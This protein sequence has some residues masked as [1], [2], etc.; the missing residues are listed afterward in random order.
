[1]KILF[2]DTPC[3]RKNKEGFDLLVKKNTIEATITTD[4]NYFHQEYDLVII[5]SQAIPPYMFPNTKRIMYGPH[6]FV[7]ANGIWAGPQQTFPGHCFYNILSDWVYELQKEFNGLSLPAKM[8]PFPV[9]TDR[10]CPSLA[11]YKYDCFIYFKNRKM[12]HR[13]KAIEAV[14]ALGL[15]YVLVEY[16]SYKEE[17]YLEILRSSRFGVWVGCHESQGFALQEALSTNVPLVVWNVKSMFDEY[18]RSNEICYK[19]DQKRYKLTATSVPYWDSRCGELLYDEKDLYSMIERMSKQYATFTPRE[20][21]LETLSP[22]A[23]YNRLIDILET[24][25]EQQR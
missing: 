11:E 13:Q 15:S 3:H 4:T 17:E 2:V 5:P 18:N 6:N 12:E 1:M 24:I 7:F 20:F 21:V 10:F 25:P 16:G 19:E 9:D 14:K 22:K 8:I 23:C